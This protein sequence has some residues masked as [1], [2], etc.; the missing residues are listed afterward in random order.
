MSKVWICKIC[1]RPNISVVNR[2][3][4]EFRWLDGECP[5]HGSQNMKLGVNLALREIRQHERRISDLQELLG[6]FD[7]EY[8]R[9]RLVEVCPEVSPP[10]FSGY[11]DATKFLRDLLYM[12]NKKI[13][14][15]RRY[16][17]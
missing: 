7:I 6:S 8:V 3:R 12:E 17:L 11:E 2:E 14:Q 15:L 9:G 5:I 10:N 13:K 16:Y 1:G 4:G